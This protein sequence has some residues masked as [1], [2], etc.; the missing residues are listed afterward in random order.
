[1]QPTFS[2]K[3]FRYP[4]RMPHKI[5]S[6][7]PR[8]SDVALKGVN[9]LLDFTFRVSPD[10]VLN[11]DSS[12]DLPT[13]PAQELRT[14]S[15]RLLAIGLTHDGQVDYDKLANSSEYMQYQ[16]L[17]AS[18]QNFDPA[19][20]AS[21]R[22]RMAFWINLY[23]ALMLNAVIHYRIS[24]SIARSLWLFR[25]AAYDIY[26]MRFSADDIE[27]GILRN[28]RRNPALPL[29][30]FPSDDPRGSYGMDP[31]DPRVHFALVCAARSCP[32][33][34]FYQAQN[35]DQQLDLAAAAFINGG[36]VRYERDSNRL[37]LSQ[38]FRWYQQDFGG[39]EAVLELI[40]R[41]LQDVDVL[42]ALKTSRPILRYMRYDWKLNGIPVFGSA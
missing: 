2:W 35:L 7:L 6:H 25:R 40:A 41:H 1:M 21:R 37:F 24:G 39:R 20:L 13:K 15:N 38:I 9:R 14:A 29:P 23:N 18:L 30:P 27:H 16:S 42:E 22:E 17:A 3:S 28:N 34:K 10:N 8:L 32:P 33:I 26:G 5:V 4:E 11:D 36:G 12:I 31:I 19:T